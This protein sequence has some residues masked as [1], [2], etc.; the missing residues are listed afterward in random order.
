[1]HDSYV[2][3]LLDDRFHQVLRQANRVSRKRPSTTT[4]MNRATYAIAPI[5]S[6]VALPENDCAVVAWLRISPTPITV[7]SAVFL[8]IAIVRF[9]SGGTVR[10][11]RCGHNT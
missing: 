6:G 8:V 7:P 5:M 2:E 4:G 3:E 9:V 11:S 1:L 10:R